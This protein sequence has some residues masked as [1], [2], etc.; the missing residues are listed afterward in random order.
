MILYS[1]N[2]LPLQ[3]DLKQFLLALR[4]DQG[5][6]AARLPPL[7]TAQKVSMVSQVAR[8]MEH[9]AAHRLTHRD[10]ATRN[11]LLTS[12]LD[13]KVNLITG[14]DL[15]LDLKVNHITSLDLNL[16]L[17]VVLVKALALTSTFR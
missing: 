7:T 4:K 15:N 3:G 11:V 9:L 12:N 14:L 5:Q 16:D 1:F 13:L 17:K 10:L 6:P 2:L 8:A